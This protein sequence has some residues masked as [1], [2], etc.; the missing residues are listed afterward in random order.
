MAEGTESWRSAH[1]AAWDTAKFVLRIASIVL[2]IPLLAISIIG[3]VDPIWF[4]SYTIIG[5]AMGAGTVSYDIAEFIVMCARKRKSGIRPAI[6]LGFELVLSFAGFAMT[7]LLVGTAIHSWPWRA[8]YAGDDR[9]GWYST[10]VSTN[11]ISN[12][13]FQ[14]S[15]YVAAS[16]LTIVLSLIHFVL[17]VRD[18]VEVDRQR[19]AVQNSLNKMTPTHSS[20]Y[21]QPTAETYTPPKMAIEHNS[22]DG[23]SKF[24]MEVI[25]Q[26][27]LLGVSPRVRDRS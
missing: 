8:F 13:Y 11:Y 7:A 18:C 14:F 4:G 27:T 9:D 17:F 21:Q 24:D 22:Y 25:E 23:S 2:G 12:P 26:K 1:Q 15:M 6:S 5:T 20:Q 16:T 10:L 19:K 3:F